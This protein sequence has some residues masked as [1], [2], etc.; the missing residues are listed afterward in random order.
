MTPHWALFPKRR[1][2]GLFRSGTHRPP[3]W[4]FAVGWCR[5]ARGRSRQVTSQVSGELAALRPDLGRHPGGFP[6]EG[7]R[8]VGSTM[9]F[10]LG[11][12]RTPGNS[13]PDPQSATPS[14]C[15]DRW[16]LSLDQSFLA[17]RYGE[18]GGTRLRVQVEGPGR[19]PRIDSDP[20]ER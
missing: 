16:F 18:P 9:S 19:G 17:R 13:L 20:C 2:A 5:E 14:V 7:G 4:C 11:A 1:V 15:I 8:P 3:R 12:S 6:P 10:S